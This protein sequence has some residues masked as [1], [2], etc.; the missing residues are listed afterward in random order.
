MEFVPTT[1]SLDTIPKLWL[2]DRLSDEL[3]STPGDAR[4]D[5]AGDDDAMEVSSE[6][7]EVANSPGDASVIKRK[8]S[9]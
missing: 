1:V 7:K 5:N 9:G 6:A 2:H 4:D 3:S 8:F